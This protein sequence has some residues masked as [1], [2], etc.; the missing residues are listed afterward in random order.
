MKRCYLLAVTA[1]VFGATGPL[2][3]AGPGPH[4]GYI[5]HEG[6]A[7]WG[8]L[9][10]GNVSCKLGKE[11]SPIDI[12]GGTK[13]QMPAI[14][15]DYRSGPLK[16]I[17]NGH[18]VQVNFDKGSSIK[19]G[20]KQYDLLQ[21]HFHTP[22]EELVNG[23]AY[24]MV[25]HLVHKSAE[26][27]LAVVGV[28]VKSGATNRA[29]DTVAASLPVQVGKEQVP[30]GVTINPASLLPANRGYYHF[31]GSLTTPPCSEGVSWYVLKD[32]IEASPGQIKKFGAIFGPNARPAQPLNARTV[33]ETL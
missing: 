11:Q 12:K 26:G 19:V 33:K 3:A 14:A 6:P 8:E 2:N 16:V 15:F 4:W 20:D 10:K 30:G 7:H 1:L 23:K 28:L 32:P 5:G 31:M 24:D 13:V 9:D 22:S 18:T 27:K 21:T 17:N 29:I 25:W